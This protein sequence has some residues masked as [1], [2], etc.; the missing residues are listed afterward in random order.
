M[1]ETILSEQFSFEGKEYGPFSVGAGECIVCP[2]PNA[3]T[4]FVESRF[5]DL[6]SCCDGFVDLHYVGRSKGPVKEALSA[7]LTG[8]DTRS[9][10]PLLDGVKEY[11]VFEGR[12]ANYSSLLLLAQKLKSCRSLVCWFTGLD[13]LGHMCLTDF[14]RDN[15]GNR[16]IL[17]LDSHMDSDDG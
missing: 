9:L 11:D 3:V 1:N 17:I 7:S 5:R 15:V 6:A 12:G 4:P 8:F 13:P 10:K 16:A 2:W 14:T